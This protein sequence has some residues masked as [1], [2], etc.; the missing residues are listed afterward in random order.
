MERKTAQAFAVWITG[1]PASGKS[2]LARAL[3]AQL[4][5]RGVDAAVLESD[6]LRKVLSDHP[7][8]DERERDT[9]YRVMTYIGVVLTEHGVPVIFDATANLRLYRERA[10]Q[11]IARFLE[12][13]VECPLESC[14]ARDPKGIYSQAREG[15]ASS[16]PGVQAPYEPPQTPDVVVHSGQEAPEPAAARVLAKLAEKSYL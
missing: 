12:V 3:E 14:M 5:A 13:Y 1:L 15:A 8:Y 16:V 2:T 9:F 4:A 10:R 7:S 6:A 11:Q